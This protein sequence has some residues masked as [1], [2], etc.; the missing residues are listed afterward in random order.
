MWPEKCPANSAMAAA[1]KMFHPVSIK[2]TKN[3]YV[4]GK[5]GM[6]FI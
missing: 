6:L 3:R 2:Q 4:F 5:P 1:G